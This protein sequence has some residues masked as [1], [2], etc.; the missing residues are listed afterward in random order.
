M[1]IPQIKIRSPPIYPIFHLSGTILSG[2]IDRWSCYC[3]GSLEYKHR[4]ARH[5]VRRTVKQSMQAKP[6][7]TESSEV[8][9]CLIIFKYLTAK[10]YECGRRSQTFCIFPLQSSSKSAAPPDRKSHSRQE[11]EAQ[12][13]LGREQKAYPT[14]HRVVLS[15]N[16]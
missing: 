7:K 12:S 3:S 2:A 13:Q 11:G 9:L 4:F 8:N 10:G 15:T 14:C 16:V 1:E 5:T 6:L